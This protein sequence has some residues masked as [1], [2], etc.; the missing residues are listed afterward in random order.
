MVEKKG[1]GGNDQT[2][3][4]A[5]GRYGSGGQSQREKTKAAIRKYSDDP[6]RD[7]SEYGGLEKKPRKIVTLPKKE[8]AELCSAIRTRYADKIPTKGHILYGKDYYQF[9]YNR[10]S[11]KIVCTYKIPIVGNEQAIS[12][13]LRKWGTKK[14]NK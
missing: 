4:P 13:W 2:Y 1:A 8:Y 10:K 3:D 12:R 6:T 7:I 11:E 9:R 14:T 5:T